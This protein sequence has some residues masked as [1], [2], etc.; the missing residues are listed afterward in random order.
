MSNDINSQSV[1]PGS[2]LS[3]SNKDEII[4]GLNKDLTRV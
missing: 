2:N 3:S 4:R 1:N